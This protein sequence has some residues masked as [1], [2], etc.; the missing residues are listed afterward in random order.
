MK[1]KKR[2]IAGF[3]MLM[4]MFVSNTIFAA[5]WTLVDV[6]YIPVGFRFQYG[7]TIY[8]GQNYL[9]TDSF[10]LK[11]NETGETNRGYC[12]QERVLTEKGTQYNL[13]EYDMATSI[14]N[15]SISDHISSYA[16]NDGGNT[17]QNYYMNVLNDTVRKSLNIA[18]M[19]ERMYYPDDQTAIGATQWFIWCQ[20]MGWASQYME[21][22]RESSNYP[23]GMG[24]QLENGY[25]YLDMNWKTWNT[26]NDNNGIF[27]SKGLY[28]AGNYHCMVDSNGNIV[29]ESSWDFD[30]SYATAD[31]YLELVN[32]YKNFD[33]KAA[34]LSKQ[35]E[36]LFPGD[37]LT[38]TDSN[39]MVKSNVEWT[40][41]TSNLPAGITAQIVDGGVKVDVSAGF[42]GYFKGTINLKRFEKNNTQKVGV[43][44]NGQQ[45]VIFHGALPIQSYDIEVEAASGK[46]RLTKA[47]NETGAVAQ[48]D[49]TL[50]GAQYEVKK[51]DGT[52]ST[53]L[54][55]DEN[56]QA[57]TDWVGLGTYYVKEIKAPTGY[58][59]SDTTYT[60]HVTAENVV[61]VYIDQT[62]GEDV[63]KGSVKINKTLSATDYD[64]AIK[65]EGAQF[66][67]TLKSDTSKVYYSNISGKNGECLIESLPY[68]TYV[69]EESIIPSSALK[70]DS[71]EV[72][73]SENKKIYTYDVEDESKL[74]VL[75]IRKVDADR[76]DTDAPDYTQGD[77]LLAGAQY[78]LYRDEDLTQ[79]IDIITIDHK[80]DE[81]YWCGESKPTRTGTYYLKETKA[82]Q[83]RLLDETVYV[84]ELDNTTQTEHIIYPSKTSSELVMRGSV[85]IKKFDNILNGTDEKP[86]EGAVLRLTLDSNPDKYYEGT[87]DEN[88]HG[89]FVEE[90][91]REKY[92]PY[93][94]PY[95]KY[96]ITEVKASNS[97]EHTHFFINPEKVTISRDTQKEYRIFSDE[98]VEM[99]LQIEKIDKDT[100]SIVSLAGARYKVWN[101]QTNS[102][103]SQKIYPSGEY[104]DEFE[105]NE[106]GK[107]TL[108]DKIEAGEYIVYETQAPAGY[109]LDEEWRIPT[110]E[111]DIGNKDKGG[112]Y[113][114][115]DK[116]AMGMEESST[117][118]GKTLYYK[119]QMPNTPLKAKLEVIKTGEKLTDV[120][121]SST[122]YGEKYTPV[123]KY[124]GLEGVTYQI[125]AAEDIKSPDGK[126][127]YV[128]KGTIVDTI[129]TGENGIA[130]T[131][132]LYLGEY[133]IEEIVTPLGYIKDENIENVVLENEDSLVKV[134]TINKEL[135]NIR[136]KLNITFE[137]EYEDVKYINEEN[138]E[139]WSV[140]GVY[141]NQEIKNSDGAVVIAKG[142]LIDIIKIEGEEISVTSTIDLPE[143]KYYVKELDTA[144]PYTVSED[145]Q[146]VTLSYVANNLEY[147]VTQLDKFVNDYEKATV[148]LI[149]VSSS[150]LGNVILTG[151]ELNVEGK[152]T[153]LE[154]MLEEL[155]GKTEAE[156]KQYLKD[157]DIKSVAGAE[158]SI[159][160]DENCEKP[161]YKIDEKT[162]EFIQVK[163]VT[164][165][166]GLI[167]LGEL[168][169]GKYYL[170]ETK[171]PAKYDLAKEVIELN[172]T[173]L[174]KDSTVYAA[175]VNDG[176]VRR[177]ITK[178]DI[179]TG[180]T[181]KDCIFEIKDESGK[182][183]LHSI[184]NENGE[185]C[186]PLDIFE[187]GKTYTYTEIEAPEIYNLNTEPHEFVAKFDENGEWAT[188]LIVV[189]NYRKESTVTL[190]KLDFADSTAIPNCKFELRSLETD[191][192]VEGVT[193]ENGIYVFENIPYGKYTYTELEAPEEY[194]IDT[195]PHEVDINAEEMKIQVTNEKAPETGD[196]QVVA[197]VGILVMSVLGIVYVAKAKKQL[198][199]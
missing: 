83:G 27:S 25:D 40:L 145:I 66:K 90:E 197:L 161:L 147:V 133:E 45:Q 174:D 127:I 42:Q 54:T 1:N 160:T 129:T 180:E 76:K 60:V 31:K 37:S 36:V 153:I 155:K 143:G 6:Q 177:V 85:T 163:L 157:K 94:I 7:N 168:P 84:Y 32:Y 172:L 158:Y 103:V 34:N 88:G 142:S 26:D 53:V 86:S 14:L 101:C 140:F 82:A 58:N 47:D 9:A 8:A 52:Y 70:V 170:K 176:I 108:P 123:Y 51:S 192:V 119:V 122:K 189:E 24:V 144:F 148:T 150:T 67:A 39:A 196:V 152:D 71:F 182:V 165:E 61:D 186:I 183:L 73:I 87:L 21:S 38:F 113:I 96:T 99:Y 184:T 63:L 179:F 62:V 13:T 112:K 146:E 120:T 57:E 49:A 20:T 117:P 79:V 35:T 178:V 110:N 191:F 132:D 190:E 10:I 74:A 199:K 137:K 19:W 141:T 91:S 187:N 128:Q 171:A 114:K 138:Q 30:V 65:L 156:V 46:I 4:L 111:S 166:S 195:T 136:Q 198:V 131:K 134:E 22:Y 97:G 33:D 55:I 194:I 69:I 100:N 89:E 56:L 28:K 106:E 105:T 173:L 124:E 48:G 135:T 78:T 109:Y 29:R 151:N 80:D 16:Y 50:V 81:G 164:D 121:V 2:L 11:N 93:T 159:F 92:Y 107:L 104:I 149:K 64:P 167:K 154:K 102:W 12:I 126:E 5:S 44:S 115:I 169:L 185:A 98:P 72:T 181:V 43:Y 116:A 41:D 68:G 17:A 139:V 175:L 95:G 193:D 3:V 75:K 118:D 77:A 23:N 15:I 18:Y 125:K 162:G 188:E 59:L 130:T